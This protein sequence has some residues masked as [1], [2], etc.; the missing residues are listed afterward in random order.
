[1]KRSLTHFGP[2]H[3][4]TSVS[5]AFTNACKPP[6]TQAKYFCL[7]HPWDRFQ[8][9]APWRDVALGSNKKDSVSL[10][11]T[12]SLEHCPE[13]APTSDQAF[14]CTPLQAVGTRHRVACLRDLIG[15]RKALQAIN[16][17]GRIAV[18]Q[19]MGIVGLST[20]R[21]FGR[22]GCKGHEASYTRMYCVCIFISR[23]FDIQIRMYI[24]KR[25]LIYIYLHMYICLKYGYLFQ[26]I[27]KLAAVI[28]TDV[29]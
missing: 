27:H 9:Q 21:G 28:G 16:P 10:F 6:Q 18:C 25:I 23:Y 29:A 22:R 26:N 13:A 1:M 24:S 12:P 17:V 14:P 2:N 3:V 7:V 19:V 4:G 20:G 8:I 15:R 5:S 11:M